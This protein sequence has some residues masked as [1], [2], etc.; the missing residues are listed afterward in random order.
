MMV[1]YETDSQARGVA[2]TCFFSASESGRLDFIIQ[3]PP[4]GR[5]RANRP[6]STV[7]ERL[8]GGASRSTLVNGQPPGVDGRG[9]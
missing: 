7:R 5:R 9:F 1:I 2:P 4:L 6:L 3:P 8:D